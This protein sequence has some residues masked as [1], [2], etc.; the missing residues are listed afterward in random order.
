MSRLTKKD[1]YGH[2]Y[3][4]EKVNDRMQADEPYPH[5][6]DGKPIDKLADYEDKEEQGLLIELPCGIGADIYSIPSETN[7]RLN[8]LHGHGEI[9]RVYHQ[10]VDRITFHENGWYME[11][12]KEREYGTGRL[13]L[14]R[15]YK[16]TWFLTEAEAEEALAK[17]G[18]K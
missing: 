14:D 12:D 13:F 17:M 6:Y 8:L 9:N 7:F 18:G 16:E 4:N 10:R 15:F 3:T 11:G 1:C 2:W 5:A